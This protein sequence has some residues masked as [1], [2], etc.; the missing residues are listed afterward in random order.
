MRSDLVFTAVKQVIA[1]C[2]DAMLL[3]AA[4]IMENVAGLVAC[5]PL[6]VSSGHVIARRK[7]AHGIVV[8]I[9]NAN[10]CNSCRTA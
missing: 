1:S 4:H 8:V 9:Y 5:G 6:A 3:A 10:V 7:N 2:L